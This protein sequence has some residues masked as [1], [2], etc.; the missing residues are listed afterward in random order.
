MSDQTKYEELKKDPARKYK[1]ELI[2]MI[3]PLE[4]EGKTTK[5]QYWYLYSTLDKVPWM[6][7]SSQIHKEGV[8]L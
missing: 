7:G 8:P 5:E 2:R 3:R 4:T 6:Y 1:A